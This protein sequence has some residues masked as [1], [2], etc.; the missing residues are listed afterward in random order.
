MNIVNYIESQH[1]ELSEKQLIDPEFL[2]LYESVELESLKVIFASLHKGFQKLFKTMNSRLPTGEHGAHFWADPSRELLFFT[3]MALGLH[4][5]L[6]K[7]VYAF[8]FEDYYYDLIIKCDSFLS[9]SGGST[10][11]PNME[12]INLYYTEPIFMVGDSQKIKRD[13]SE[14][15]AKLKLIG[16][17]SYAIV[18]KFKDEFYN[19]LFVLKRAKANLNQTE[20]ERFK[21]EF[22]EMKKLSSPYILEVYSF[23][24]HKNEYLMEYMDFSL[25]EYVAKNNGTLDVTTRKGM[26]LQVLRAFKYLSSK[27]LLHRDISP[28]N[29]LLKKYDDIIVVKVSDFGLVK[30]PDSSLTSVNTE[31]KGYFNDPALITEG[32]DNYSFCHEVFA[33]TKLIFYIMTG[34][35]NTSSIQD[36][37]LKSFTARG[38]NV[39][40]DNRFQSIDEMIDVVKTF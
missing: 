9:K 17:G 29:I 25:D 31:F 1:R 16:E 14:F 10:L 27:G 18:Y 34:K 4:R 5:S 22:D 36:L 6:K 26:A 20:L 12:K 40:R 35:T 3:E 37:S 19:K 24:I 28:K 38:L 7:S 33:L 13:T 32:F 11:P 39:D 23:D 8:E 15:H 2:G 21:R 30:I